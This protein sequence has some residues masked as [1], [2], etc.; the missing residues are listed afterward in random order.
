MSHLRLGETPRADVPETTEEIYHIFNTK[1]EKQ[2]KG[3]DW[4][5]EQRR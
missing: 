2:K 1:E 4:R 5:G 3:G